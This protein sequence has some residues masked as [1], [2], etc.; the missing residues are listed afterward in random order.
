MEM[1]HPLVKLGFS[2]GL[3]SPRGFRGPP[4]R[5]LETGGDIVSRLFVSL[6]G[7]SQSF[8]SVL[9]VNRSSCWPLCENGPNYKHDCSY[10]LLP[11]S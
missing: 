3:E 10:V 1:R 11:I 5:F 7:V 9:V 8:F 6:C 2:V 4:C